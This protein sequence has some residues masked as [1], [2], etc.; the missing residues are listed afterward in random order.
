MTFCM[1]TRI[2]AVGVGPSALQRTCRRASSS[3]GPRQLGV[4]FA[5]LDQLGAALCR[6]G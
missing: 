5:Q 4:L 6:A 3:A 1:L 2:S